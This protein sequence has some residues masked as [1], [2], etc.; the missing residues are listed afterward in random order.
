MRETVEEGSAGDGLRVG[1]ARCFSGH[2]SARSRA[3]HQ[4]S[5]KKEG[6]E[7]TGVFLTNFS[8]VFLFFKKN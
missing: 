1:E 6:G 4:V 2:G 5:G 3:W 7:L 8:K